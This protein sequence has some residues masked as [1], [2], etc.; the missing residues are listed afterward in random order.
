METGAPAKQAPAFFKPPQS[1]AC[2]QQ[3]VVCTAT[4][5]VLG[6]DFE[7]EVTDVGPPVGDVTKRLTAQN[8]QDREHGPAH[9]NHGAHAFSRRLA[10]T[11]FGSQTKYGGSQTIAYMPSQEGWQ[12]LVSAAKQ[13]MEAVRPRHA[14]LN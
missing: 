3:C 7:D 8:E 1:A 10:V 14:C 12:F 4:H 11:S 9:P 6:E 13:S 2:Q 5:Q